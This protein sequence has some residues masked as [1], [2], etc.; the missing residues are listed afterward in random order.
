MTG[1]PNVQRVFFLDRVT[2]SGEKYNA[3]LVAGKLYLTI[4]IM[5]RKCPL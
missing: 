1:V 3:L 4:C 2:K 5:E